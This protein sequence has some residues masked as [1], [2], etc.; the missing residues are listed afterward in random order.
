MHSARHA[1]AC[2]REQG[3]DAPARDSLLQA[4][5]VQE[6]R[7]FGDFQ[8][9]VTSCCARQR[10]CATS[11]VLASRALPLERAVARVCQEA[12]ARVARDVRLSEMNIDF[13]VS[14]DRRIEVV[15]NG[16]YLWHGASAP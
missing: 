5:P 8:R 1:A 7:E 2:L 10:P 4:R 6:E 3:Y 14:D 11:G 15:V 13:P 16:L 12:G 9:V